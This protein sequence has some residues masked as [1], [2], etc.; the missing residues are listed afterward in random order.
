[1]EIYQKLLAN[2]IVIIPTTTG[3]QTLCLTLVIIFV[4]R[5]WRIDF[6]E[7]GEDKFSGI[8]DLRR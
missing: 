5:G 6:A 8:R 3:N 4:R 7:K 2:Q 1:M